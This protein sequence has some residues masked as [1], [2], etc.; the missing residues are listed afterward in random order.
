MLR[1]SAACFRDASSSQRAEI[2]RRSR[3]AA[4][5]AVRRSIP[6]SS[7]AGFTLGRAVGAGA[8]GALCYFLYAL[9][10]AYLGSRTG[11]THA[12]LTRSILGV[13]GSAL[14][15]LLLIVIA[16]TWK[17]ISYNFL[18]FL[19]G[20]QSIPKSLIEAAAIDGATPTRRFWTIIF[21]LLL[22]AL[23][24]QQFNP[25]LAG[26]DDV[27]PVLNP[28]LWSFWIPFFII[29]TVA[30]I[31]FAFVIYFRGWSYALAGVNVLL[32]VA[33]AAPAVW[34]WVMGS[35]LNPAFV[36]AVALQTDDDFDEAWRITSIIVVVSLV[37]IAVWDVIDGFY[38]AYRVRHPRL[39]SAR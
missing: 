21:P 29:L 7:S 24:W 12:L 19:A 13:T 33:F 5:T 3:I 31:A 15:S 4:S 1:H 34:L 36:D 38:N 25:Y 37:A 32:N 35:I 22:V 16:A 6:S 23:V 20:L 18:F 27:L 8:L 2:S 28:E 26:S 14:V 17:Q 9:P 30:E 39:A 10:A 11:Q